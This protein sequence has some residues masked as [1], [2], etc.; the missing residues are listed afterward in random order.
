MKTSNLI[1]LFATIIFMACENSSVETEW[2]NLTLEAEDH[3]LPGYFVT[4]MAFDSQ[5]VAWI[6]TFAHGLIRY[7]QGMFSIYNQANFENAADRI[8]DIAID[9]HDN[10]WIGTDGLVKYD[11][12]TFTRFDNSNTIMPENFVH[13]V[14]V[15]YDDVV[16]L[17][18]SVFQQ[19][20]LMKYNGRDFELFTPAN[21]KAPENM[22]I[23]IT[24]DHNNTK[25][26][27]F[28]KYVNEVSMVKINGN[29]WSLITEKE[30]GFQ[31]YYWGA[32]AVNT[33]NSLIASI[34][35][36]LSSSM[37]NTRPS[38]IMYNNGT[39]TNISPVNDEGQSLGNVYSI[40]CDQSGYVWVGLGMNPSGNQF[41]VFNGKKWFTGQENTVEGT[42]FAMATD[43]SNR[44]W[45]G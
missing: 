22:V 1:I 31:P 28:A 6:G 2:P 7:E 11:G 27:T 29:N 42:I 30:I 10:V 12:V 38:L 33:D 34:D 25:W 20:G 24:V 8:W 5:G 44:T 18:A 19:G 17:S 41:A 35:Y 21:S 4:A 45:L 3:I 9:S 14:A 23:D 36:S 39:W 40:N 15:D 26:V 32:L 37:D 16:W 13:N 43:A